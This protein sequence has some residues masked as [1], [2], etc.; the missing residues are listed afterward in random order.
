MTPIEGLVRRA[1]V[2]RRVRF[3]AQHPIGPYRADFYVP[4]LLLVIECDGAP[5]HSRPHQVAH[6]RRR[7]AYM[8]ARGYRVA[9]LRG[10]SIVRDARAATARALGLAEARRVRRGR[11]DE[12]AVAAVRAPRVPEG[13]EV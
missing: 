7:D 9:R 10:A 13:E 5:W 8:R 1:L 4:A 11:A 2:E 3:L 6:D 12:E